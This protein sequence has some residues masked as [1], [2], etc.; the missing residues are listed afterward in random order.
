MAGEARILAV[1]AGVVGFCNG[2]GPV[3]RQFY[4]ELVTVQ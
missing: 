2:F 3:F 1:L 4:A